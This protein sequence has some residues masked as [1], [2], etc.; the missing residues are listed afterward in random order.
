MARRRPGR[1]DAPAIP[2]IE[3]I[4]GPDY[5]TV[6][7]ICAKRLGFMQ[8]LN[9]WKAFGCGWARRVAD[10]EAKGVAWALTAAN[11]N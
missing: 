10:I 6:K 7:G 8:P 11:D 5:D 3:A 2:P 1:S 4:G 9:I